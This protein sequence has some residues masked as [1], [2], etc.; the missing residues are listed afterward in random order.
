MLAGAA[1]PPRQTLL[2]PNV[3]RCLC[4]P[5]LCPVRQKRACTPSVTAR[6]VPGATQRRLYELV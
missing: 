4:P 1:S 5:P 2:T 6:A 3:I